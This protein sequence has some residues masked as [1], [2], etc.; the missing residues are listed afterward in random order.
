MTER[1]LYIALNMISGVGYTRCKALLERF[2]SPDAVR[3]AERG[4]LHH[5][6]GFGKI[7]AE[8]MVEFDW[9]AELSRELATAERGGVQIITLADE[10]YPSELR[11]LFD[12]PLCLYIRGALPDNFER[13]I[14]IVGSRRISRYG[15]QMA[16]VLAREAADSGF[17]VYSGLAMGVDTIAHKAVTACGGRTVGV[18]GAGLMHM[19]PP[20]NIQL[21]RDIIANGGAVISEFPLD[22][23]VSRHNFPRRNRIVAALS[24]ATLIVEAGLESG[25]LITAH[26]AAELGREVFAVPGR[27]DNAQARGC[28]QLI[29]DGAGLVEN[30]DDVLIALHFGGRTKDLGGAVAGEPVT[31]ELPPE[32]MEIYRL[33]QDG[34]ADLETLQER[35][36]KEPG[37]LLA[38]LMKLELKRLVERDAEHFYRLCGTPKKR[39]R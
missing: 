12:P 2:G 8:R 28:H 11:D 16:E 36:G 26:L 19:Y 10:N 20:E 14:A 5:V 22:Y 31:V 17:A 4:E 6:P 21:A 38:S 33:L 7:L 15:E 3:C 13:T 24:R 29:K 27:V 30:F 23:P 35:T 37:Q 9:D 1:E 32:C 39:S 25:A 34:E 18:L